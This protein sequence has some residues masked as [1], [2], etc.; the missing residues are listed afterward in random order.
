MVD[1]EPRMT[2]GE[3]SLFTSFLVK[4]RTYVEFGIGGSSVLAS[5]LVSG[6]I[7]GIESDMGWID[8]VSEAC[9]AQHSQPILRHVDIGPTK[10]WGFPADQSAKERW[11]AYSTK[12]WEVAGAAGAD[13]Y[14]VD[15]RFRV[16]CFAQS[17]IHARRDSI[18]AIHDF[19]PRSHYHCVDQLAREIARYEDLSFFV[20]RSNASESARRMHEAYCFAPE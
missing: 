20:P 15:G 8:L 17:V 18:I 2:K 14:L 13:L 12:I 9:R 16:A 19:A 7:I 5:R 4:A 3:I 6:L 1:I 10:E 11:P